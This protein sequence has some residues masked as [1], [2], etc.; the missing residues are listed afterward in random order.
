M[1]SRKKL[2]RRP[3]SAASSSKQS[4]NAKLRSQT[5]D[6][7]KDKLIFGPVLPLFPV[8]VSN[9]YDFKNP[10]LTDEQLETH[11]VWKTIEMKARAVAWRVGHPDI[12]L[13]L[14]HE[15]FII[16]RK[17][18]KFAGE[19]SLETYLYTVLYHKALEMIRPLVPGK[20]KYVN[21]DDE[22]A[23]RVAYTP[24]RFVYLDD[25]ATNPGEQLVDSA[26]MDFE[27]FLLN[28]IYMD[29]ALKELA[30]R[31][32]LHQVIVEIVRAFIAGCE[33][34]DDDGDAHISKKARTRNKDKLSERFIARTASKK[35]GREVNRYQVQSVL[36]EFC[37]VLYDLLPPKV[38]ESW[39][40]SAFL[41]RRTHRSISPS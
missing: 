5:Q 17:Q 39:P 30:E 1:K 20:L 23:E 27:D 32:D 18:G 36:D 8:D 25:Q 26:T 21:H 9:F 2:S 28:G 16:C 3:Q 29:E 7:N 31:S 33:D 41:V 13:E 15:V 37:P 22:S 19:K 12:W 24:W 34:D 35:L 4:K 10:N 11:P 14:A 6:D 40:R 38:R